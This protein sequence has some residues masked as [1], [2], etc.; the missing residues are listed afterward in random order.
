[1]FIFVIFVLLSQCQTS[2]LKK[3]VTSILKI[4]LYYYVLL[5]YF[6]YKTMQIIFLLPEVQSSNY[7]RNCSSYII[8]FQH[9][10]P[11]LI[12]TKCYVLKILR[13]ILRLIS[14]VWPLF[15]IKFFFFKNGGTGAQM[16]ISLC[17]STITCERWYPASVSFFPTC[18]FEIVK[19]LDTW[20]LHV[21]KSCFGHYPGFLLH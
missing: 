4:L 5:I 13:K 21:F 19:K 9:I 14:K 6:I 2:Y 8:I 10:L 11:W 18:K 12:E 20:I 16:S 3:I 1:M 7:Y 17:C 15:F